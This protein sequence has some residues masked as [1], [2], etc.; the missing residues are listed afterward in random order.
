MSITA[1]DEEEDGCCVCA[2]GGWEDDNLIVIC[3]GTDCP[4]ATHQ[5][6]YGIQMVPKDTLPWFCDVCVENLNPKD[7]Q[8]AL[9]GVVDGLALKKCDD[10]SSWVHALVSIISSL[11]AHPYN[12]FFFY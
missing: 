6:C 9:C 10:G 4:T 3:D 1:S 8:C 5:K 12:D 11:T 2:D 7:L